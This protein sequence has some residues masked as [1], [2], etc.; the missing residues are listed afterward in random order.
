MTT[1]TTTSQ[2]EKVRGLCE[3]RGCAY[4]DTP[5]LT[6]HVVYLPGVDRGLAVPVEDEIV[7]IVKT[8]GFGAR[9]GEQGTLV[10]QLYDGHH[11]LDICFLCHCSVL[12]FIFRSGDG[13]LICYYSLNNPVTD[14]RYSGQLSESCSLVA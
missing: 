9:Y 14:A 13:S 3:Q 4:F 2:R 7:W 5:S 1:L 6:L 11:G 12:L 8:L 10:L